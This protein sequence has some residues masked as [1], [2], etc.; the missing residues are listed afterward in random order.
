MASAPH[1]ERTHNLS[2]M[3]TPGADFF[4]QQS[5]AAYAALERTFRNALVHSRTGDPM[6]WNGLSAYAIHADLPW[7]ILGPPGNLF[8]PDSMS[9]A[10]RIVFKSFTTT[11]PGAVSAV[12]MYAVSNMRIA[13]DG[14][15][16]YGL[17]VGV[18]YDQMA[19]P[20]GYESRVQAMSLDHPNQVVSSIPRDDIQ[21]AVAFS[22]A[23]VTIGNELCHAILFTR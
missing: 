12:D 23:A 13:A 6:A 21:V 9:S 18:Y 10:S 20:P 1:I 19:M 4:Q 2:A 14:R 3:N 8:P 15:V 5:D 17:R 11:G 16:T 22:G 7:I